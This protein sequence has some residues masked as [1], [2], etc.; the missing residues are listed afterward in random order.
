M[1]KR[2]APRGSVAAYLRLNEAVH[3]VFFD[4]RYQQRPVYMEIAD[5]RVEEL[6]AKLGVEEHELDDFM[7]LAVAESFMHGSIGSLQSLADRRKRV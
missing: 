2:I 7:G 3:E 1:S 6:S 4:G 5:D